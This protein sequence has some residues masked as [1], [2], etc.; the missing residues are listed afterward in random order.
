MAPIVFLCIGLLLWGQ[1]VF[2]QKEAVPTGADLEWVEQHLS[3]ATEKLLPL[4]FANRGSVAFRGSKD[5]FTEIP[6]LYF[7]IT[8]TEGRNPTPQNIESAIVLD[9]LGRS[10]REH[11]VELR[12]ADRDAALDELL[13]RTRI[14]RTTLV[15]ARCP[16]I[17]NRLFE[18]SRL[19]IPLPQEREAPYAIPLHPLSNH[20]VVNAGISLDTYSTDVDEP[21]VRW[22]LTTLDAL[23]AC[24]PAGK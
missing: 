23:K 2:Y 7:A 13:L 6:E 15:P 19:S 5:R 16:A 9:M 4:K 14:R 22:A 12:M 1:G 8:F 17:T 11:L 3:E 20:L 21:W 10:V 24:A 18:L